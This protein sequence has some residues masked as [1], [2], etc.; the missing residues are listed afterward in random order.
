[1]TNSAVP[2]LNAWPFRVDGAAVVHDAQG[3]FRANDTHTVAAMVLQGLGIG[4]LATLAGDLLVGQGRLVPVLPEQTD[5]QPVPLQAVT[6]GTRHRLP[7][8]KACL[9]Y[10]AEWF[11]AAPAP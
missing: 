4:R 10:W 8:I 11:A 9:D 2:A 5:R 7:K 6:A 1:M 3:H